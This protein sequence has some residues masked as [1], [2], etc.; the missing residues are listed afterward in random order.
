MKENGT[1]YSLVR[2]RKELYL[3]VKRLKTTYLYS[4]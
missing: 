2:A 4:R 1:N 3:P